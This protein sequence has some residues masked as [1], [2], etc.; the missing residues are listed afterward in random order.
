MRWPE[1]NHARYS[2]AHAFSHPGLP[3]DPP[4]AGLDLDRDGDRSSERPR[5]HRPDH[6]RQRR[7]H[8]PHA[9]AAVHLR[10]AVRRRAGVA[11]RLPGAV[12]RHRRARHLSSAARALPPDSRRSSARPGGDRPQPPSRLADRRR[13]LDHQRPAPGPVSRHAR[14]ARAGLLPLY[15][16]ALLVGA[17]HR[18]LFPARRHPQLPTA[19]QP[20]RGRVQAH[21]GRS[22]RPVRSL[23]GV[24]PRQQG[25]EAQPRPAADL[26][27]RRAHTHRRLH[28]S[29]LVQR[30]H[31]V[32]RRDRLGEPAVLHR[33]GHGALHPG[34]G[35]GPPG[36][37]GV[38]AQPALLEDAARGHPGGASHLDSRHRRGRQARPFRLRAA[39]ELRP[40]PPSRQAAPLHRV[41][42]VW[43]SSR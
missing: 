2:E 43:T 9:P 27:R 7:A 21:A 39:P 20:G 1:E 36:A 11:P 38:H 33:H 12:Q 26:R 35:R 17:P 29:L 18:P 4:V 34:L 28:P 5:V 19:D 14:R 37:F 40:R 23:P 42:S 32:H 3:D 25:A 6:R 13:H 31:H 8:Q 15:G 41:G 10:R 24:D 22:G 16:L 30:Q